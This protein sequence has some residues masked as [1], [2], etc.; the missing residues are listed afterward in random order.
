[1]KKLSLLISMILCVTISGVYAA[2]VFAGNNIVDKD[3][4]ITIAMGEV[5]NDAATP[6]TYSISTNFSLKI[7]PLSDVEPGTSV[8]HANHI[9]AIDW[10]LDDGATEPL[11]TF[12][13]TPTDAATQ[14]Q[15]ANGVTSQ[16]YLI[17]SAALAGG[18]MSYSG[19]NI[20]KFGATKG[21]PRTINAGGDVNAWTKSGNAFTYTIKAKD[22]ISLNDGEGND[23]ERN[24]FLID[25][26]E[27]WNTFNAA[28]AGNIVIYITD[29]V[30]DAT[31]A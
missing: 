11:I 5:S 29:T 20:F 10:I 13:F 22:F 9:V 16:F 14:E 7:E 17:T 2:W 25:T 6:G 8:E 18:E 4:T 1:M 19:R 12:T 15:K 30:T 28:I 23:G 27:D 21:D 3:T 26:L 24:Y 31:G